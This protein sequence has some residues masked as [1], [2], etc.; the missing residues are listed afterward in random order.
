MNVA[1]PGVRAEGTRPHYDWQ[2]ELVGQRVRALPPFGEGVIT[3]IENHCAHVAYVQL[4]NG[5]G[6]YW[7]FDQIE[8]LT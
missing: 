5:V 7:R 1:P 2:H 4:D 6:G 8:L 3:I